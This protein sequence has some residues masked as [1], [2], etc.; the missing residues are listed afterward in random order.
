MDNNKTIVSRGI[1]PHRY[2]EYSDGSLV[3]TC[4]ECGSVVN[5]E[6]ETGRKI[7]KI[8]EWFTKFTCNACWSSKNSETYTKKK[9]TRLEEILVGQSYNLAQQDV[10]SQGFNPDDEIYWEL[11]ER[12]RLL[13]YSALLTLRNKVAHNNDLLY[14]VAQKALNGENIPISDYQEVTIDSDTG[15]PIFDNIK[16]INENKKAYKRSDAYKDKQKQ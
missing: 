7:K 10:I 9:D 1:F 4:I 12:W 8:P 3:A 5:V 16:I 6:P 13:H 11:I 2:E 15:E 14:D